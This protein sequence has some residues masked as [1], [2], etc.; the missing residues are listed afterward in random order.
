MKKII[1]IIIIISAMLMLLAGTTN[2]Q[3]YNSVWES[4]TG[5]FPDEICPPYYET[6]STG[7]VV[8]VFEDDTLVIAG[9]TTAD[10][11]WFNMPQSDLLIPSTL[12]VE[13]KLRI[14]SDALGNENTGIQYGV[15]LIPPM[16]F[17]IG[18]GCCFSLD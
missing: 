6:N 1:T 9:P 4:S 18:E 7:I 13:A 11:N 17:G 2:A 12:V 16:F 15:E 8:P 14:A 5:E 3:T 10:Y